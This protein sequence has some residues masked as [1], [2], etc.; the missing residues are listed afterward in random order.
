MLNV[1]VSPD[2]APAV[3]K[4]ADYFN[5]RQLKADGRCVSVSVNTELPAV[6]AGQID[7]QRPRPHPGIDA[8]IPDSSLW[9]DQARV[10]ALGAETVQPAGYSVAL[11]RCMLVMPKGR[12]SAHR[13]VRQDRLASAAP[14]LGA[15]PARSFR[16]ARQPA[17][18]DAERGRP[19]EPG[20]DGPR[21]SATAR[22]PGPVHQ[23][24][25]LL[26]GDVVL[27]RPEFA[28]VLREPGRAAANERPGNGHDRA[29]GARLRPGLSD[30]P[31][32]AKYPAGGKA[33]AGSPEL[34]YP[35]CGDHAATGCGDA[36]GLFGKVLTSRTRRA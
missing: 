7:G 15:R 29:G 5:R 2:I 30:Q 10:Y 24:R 3:T 18:P 33:G 19:R 35:V 31:L 14:E 6:A 23:V 36:A 4:I 22:R 11:S 26:P 12:G 17:R 13:R 1:A 8:W 21:C 20:R 28:A 34:D 25:L 32:A 27:R 9:V 16:H